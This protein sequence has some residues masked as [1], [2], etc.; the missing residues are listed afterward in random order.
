[1]GALTAKK[2][3]FT[4]R[5]WENK[6]FQEIDETEVSLFRIRVEK[7]KNRR[8]R[9]LPIKYW[10]ANE[11]RS[12]YDKE[13][14]NTSLLSFETLSYYS[15]KGFTYLERFQVNY[16]SD[17]MK[18]SFKILQRQLSKGCLNIFLGRVLSSKTLSRSPMSWNLYFH[19]FYND[20]PPYTPLE[21]TVYNRFNLSTSKVLLLTN[22]RYISPSFNS[23]LYTKA[24]EVD[25]DIYSLSSFATSFIVNAEIPLSFSSLLSLATTKE[26][27]DDLTI[28]TSLT[29]L[30]ISINVNVPIIN[31]Y[32]LYLQTNH[33]FDILPRNT[34][35]ELDL[36]LSYGIKQHSNAFVSPLSNRL[37]NSSI[38]LSLLN[39][40]FDHYLLK[41]I[42]LKL[43]TR[44]SA[45]MYLTSSHDKIYYYKNSV[46]Y[47]KSRQKRY[48]VNGLLMN[49]L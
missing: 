9:I 46:R 32:P 27:L 40:S 31:L 41:E 23:F 36:D 3:A 30:P 15:I 42:D 38:Y 20:I 10:I 24:D 12:R 35:L 37:T 6:S 49:N 21:P 44:L 33:T 8:L 48:L 13:V 39:H 28:V 5:S 45:L 11:K 26:M 22:P 43:L 16:L 17:A 14:T 4:Y 25:L 2:S 7:L 1:M 34:N 29:D 47:T 19:D 18:V